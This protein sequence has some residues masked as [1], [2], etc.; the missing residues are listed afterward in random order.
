MPY[1]RPGTYSPSC[2]TCNKEY[3]SQTSRSLDLHYKEHIRYINYNNPQSAYALHILNNQ[4]KYGPID[5]TI[6]LLKPLKITSLL[7]LTNTVSYN[8]STKL[9]GSSPNGTL[10]PPPS[11]P[12]SHQPLP[13]SLL[14]LP[15]EFQHSHSAPSSCPSSAQ[16]QPAHAGMYFSLLNPSHN[17]HYLY[18]DLPDPYMPLSVVHPTL[19][20][21]TQVHGL[22]NNTTLPHIPSKPPL[23]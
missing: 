18:S 9:A 14:T 4:H 22:N 12:A 11:A 3:V 13:P 5:K 20:P 8:P 21:T 17:L 1:D 16:P 15:V 19:L 10:G 23:L 2:L 6:T 7:S